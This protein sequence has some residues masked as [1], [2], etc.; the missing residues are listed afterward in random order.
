MV[1]ATLI[2][3]IRIIVP[4]PTPSGYPTVTVVAPTSIVSTV[5]VIVSVIVLVIGIRPKDEGSPNR[6]YILGKSFRNKKA[7]QK[8]E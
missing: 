8:N 3:P 6:R 1:P 7:R 2:P 4:I 5:V